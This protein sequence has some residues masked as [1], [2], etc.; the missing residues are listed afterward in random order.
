MRSM[1]Q[2]LFETETSLSCVGRWHCG[3]L[4][5]A[6]HPTVS[7]KLLTQ[8]RQSHNDHTCSAGTLGRRASCGWLNNVWKY[9]AITAEPWLLLKLKDT[10][11]QKG[12]YRKKNQNLFPTSSAKY[13]RHSRNFQTRSASLADVGRDVTA[14][15]ARA[16]I[17]DSFS[18]NVVTLST[19]RTYWTNLSCSRH[20]RAFSASTFTYIHTP[21]PPLPLP[22]PSDIPV[23]ETQTDTEMIDISKTHTEKIFNTDTIYI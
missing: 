20:C 17:S 13:N 5:F 1:H 4:G 11:R 22:P 23:T 6:V 21:P 7:S 8:P 10:Q 12:N 14:L 16:N 2:V 19:S 15:S 3:D 9:S 18:S